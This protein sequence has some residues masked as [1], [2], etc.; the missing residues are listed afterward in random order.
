MGVDNAAR[1]PPT[2]IRTFVAPLN[3][4]PLRT[5]RRSRSFN[6]TYDA[7][8]VSSRKSLRRPSF[9]GVG[10]AARLP[11]TERRTFVAPLN[12]GPS[13]TSRRSQSFD[14]TTYDA[15]TAPP[16]KPLRGPSF[17]GADI[18]AR[19]PLTETR[20]FAAPLKQVSSR[21]SGRSQSFDGTYD[22]PTASSRTPLR[23]LSIGGA[24]IAA[25]RPPTETR[26]FVAPLKEVSLRKSGRNQSFDATYDAPVCQPPGIV[27]P[28]VAPPHDPPARRPGSSRI[29]S[30]DDSIVR[31]P[32]HQD[33]SKDI[34]KQRHPTH[35]LANAP[36]SRSP[37]GY[38]V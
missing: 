7:P 37:E 17:E 21:K 18:A 3:E 16:R 23:S 34:S 9:V 1:L 24:D 25:R 38:E 6:G 27:R 8:T 14:G 28:F 2:E 32:R 4:G 19:R 22:A 13:R 5:S 20:R 11:P 33:H 10:N 31:P 35:F 15:P 30:V 26:T 36:S 12:E 29:V